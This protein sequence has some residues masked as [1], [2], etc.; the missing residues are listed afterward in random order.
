MTLKDKLQQAVT[1]QQ[2]SVVLGIITL[3]IG[4]LFGQINRVDDKVN[5]Y[6][7]DQYDVLLSISQ[8]VATI[9]TA[10]NEMKPRVDEMYR[11]FLKQGDI[12]S[13]ITITNG[14]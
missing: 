14:N 7:K 13:S 11:S 10:T 3:S 8:D 1:W 5:T 2:I 6:L 4:W 12:T 9:R